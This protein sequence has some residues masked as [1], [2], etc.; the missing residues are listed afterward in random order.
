MVF[1]H[2][3]PWLFEL[4]FQ[5]HDWLV[6][7]ESLTAF[8]HRRGKNNNTVGACGT[9]TNWSGYIFQVYSADWA[10]AAGDECLS[11]GGRSLEQ[12]IVS[13]FRDSRQRRNR[14]R[15]RWDEEGLPKR[16]EQIIRREKTICKVRIVGCCERHNRREVKN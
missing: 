9:A 10:I 6:S 15:F 14:S 13:N 12:T 11:T 2:G 1:S 8:A 16:P 3:K 4:S 5:N 7:L